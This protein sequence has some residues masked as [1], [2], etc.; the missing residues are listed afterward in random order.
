MGASACPHHL[1]SGEL[2]S[3][4]ELELATKEL[5]LL[6]EEVKLVES[7]LENDKLVLIGDGKE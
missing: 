7:V 3:D 1:G 4:D 5:V 6:V 2:S